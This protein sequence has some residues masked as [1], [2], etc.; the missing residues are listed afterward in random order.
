MLAQSLPEDLHPALTH[1][2]EWLETFSR[3]PETP[4]E[5]F[6]VSKGYDRLFAKYMVRMITHFAGLWAE[7]RNKVERPFGSLLRKLARASRP[8][9]IAKLALKLQTLLRRSSGTRICGAIAQSGFTLADGELAT[10]VDAAASKDKEACA[11]LCQIARAIA[12]HMPDPRGRL[13]SMETATHLFLL[14][15]LQNSGMP[16]A[17]TWD[18]IEEED[19]TDPATCATRQATGCPDFDPR[20]AV[21]LLRSVDEI[22]QH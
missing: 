16:V 14:Y 2:A 7:Q 1:A 12:P 6:L 5:A 20:S 3:S 4:Y 22:R 10:V 9:N 11:R 19:Y 17:Y 8:S 15:E 18:P 13:V 21:K